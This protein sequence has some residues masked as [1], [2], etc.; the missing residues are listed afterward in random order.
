MTEMSGSLSEG[1]RFGVM[2]EVQLLGMEDVLH[3]SR[4]RG[5]GANSGTKGTNGHVFESCLVVFLFLLSQSFLLD[6]LQLLETRVELVDAIHQPFATQL[7]L[8]QV[9]LVHGGDF[10]FLRNT[11][12]FCGGQQPD[13]A[14]ER[15]MVANGFSLI[16]RPFSRSNS[17]KAISEGIKKIRDEP[18]APALAVRPTRWM[19]SAAESGGSYWMTQASSGRSQPRAAT[20]VQINTPEALVRKRSKVS[21]RSSWV[22]LPCILKR[23][24]GKKGSAACCDLAW[25]SCLRFSSLPFWILS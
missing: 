5:V 12:G 8:L 6:L 7:Q 18:F 4:V 3:L 15:I 21:L 17:M 24:W 10:G 19:Y 16:L 25:E 1:Q 9:H 23:F 13:E 20:S 2:T 22:M 14:T 11:V